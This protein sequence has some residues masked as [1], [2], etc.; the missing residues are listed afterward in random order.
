[1]PSLMRACDLVIQNSGGLTSLEARQVGLPVIT[2]RCL[3][4]HGHTNARALERAGWAPWARDLEDLGVLVS[5]ALATCPPG[6]GGDG[7]VDPAL[8]GVGA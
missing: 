8:T 6:D 3:P 7:V 2:Y 5:A 4:G 1:M